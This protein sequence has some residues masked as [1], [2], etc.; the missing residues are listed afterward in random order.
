[1]PDHSAVAPEINA[2]AALF[3]AF[4]AGAAFI[5]LGI[6]LMVVAPVF[7]DDSSWSP[8]HRLAAIGMDKGALPLPANLGAA[9]ITITT[10]IYAGLSLI[11]AFLFALIVRG[12]TFGMVIFLGILFGLLV[13]LIGFYSVAPMLP[14]LNMARG[15]DV[16]II[17]LTYGAILGW[18]YGSVARKTNRPL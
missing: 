13:Y 2:K 9:A 1:M 7:V 3:A 8:A 11:L 10:A 14:G 17:H 6:L 4:I 5:M 15:W 12:R 18:V 16:I